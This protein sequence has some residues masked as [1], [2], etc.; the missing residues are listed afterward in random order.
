MGVDP[1]GVCKFAPGTTVKLGVIYGVIQGIKMKE[2][3]FSDE[4]QTAFIGEFRG[5]SPEGVHYVSEKAYFFK[6]L[7]EKLTAT[8]E[9][10]GQKPVEFAYE[11]SSREVEKA[12]L[13]Y[14]Y[15]AASLI[16]TAASDRMSAIAQAVED[17]MA[18]R[19]LPA[20]AGAPSPATQTPEESKKAE[21]KT[22]ARN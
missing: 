5:I 2:S 6:A 8:F 17:K 18:Q 22:K 12:Q 10:G 16:P 19:A 7:S 13:G 14:E 3:N 11:I 21:A 4:L 20:A 15:V 1:T 9:T